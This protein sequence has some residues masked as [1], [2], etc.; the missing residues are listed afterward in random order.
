MRL[1]QQVSLG[2]H[3]QTVTVNTTE[4]HAV[5]QQIC[6]LCL[7]LFIYFPGCCLALYCSIA[8]SEYIG[9]WVWSQV[10][11]QVSSGTDLEVIALTDLVLTLSCSGQV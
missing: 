7:Y 5:P 2:R 8:T 11:V 3:K 4:K 1:C 9:L 6:T 10:I